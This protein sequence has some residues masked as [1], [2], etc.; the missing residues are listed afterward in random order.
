MVDRFQ[1]VLSHEDALH[2]ELLLFQIVQDGRHRGI[3]AD[4]GL[5]FQHLPTMG[6]GQIVDLHTSGI[7]PLEAGCVRMNGYEQDIVK[8]VIPQRVR[9]VGSFFQFEEYIGVS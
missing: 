4:C 7:G 6:G 8:I 5:G 2:G 1:H 3:K 9:D